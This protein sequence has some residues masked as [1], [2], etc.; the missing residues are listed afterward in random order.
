MGS[1]EIRFMWKTGSSWTGD[2]P[3][4]YSTDGGYYVQ[5][6]RVTDPGVRSRLEALGRANDS[7]LGADEDFG[8]VPADV[9]DRIRELWPGSPRTSTRACSAS[10][11][12]PSGSKG[13][14]RTGH[15]QLKPRH[16]PVS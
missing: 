2:C 4:L 15:R 8:F 6:K 14:G 9:I 13:S 11:R 16:S 10:A 12:M 1:E 7:P 5:V 3:A